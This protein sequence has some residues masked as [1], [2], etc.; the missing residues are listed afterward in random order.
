MN[1]ALRTQSRAIEQTLYD[2]SERIIISAS[3]GERFKIQVGYSSSRDRG[4]LFIMNGNPGY[5]ISV[6][7]DKPSRDH[8][9]QD[10]MGAFLVWLEKDLKS[11]YE[12]FKGR[13]I[14]PD[15]TKANLD[16]IL[17]A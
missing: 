2:I 13:T 16:G 8:T 10:Y 1:R 14:R 6:K 11:F 17:A 7:F 9:Q 3:D 12:E 5:I 4:H 15:E